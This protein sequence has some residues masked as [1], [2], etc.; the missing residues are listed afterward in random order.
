[1]KD[2]ERAKLFDKALSK[3]KLKKKTLFKI[4]L[5]IFIILPIIFLLLRLFKTIIYNKNNKNEKIFE[6]KFLANNTI[7]IFNIS[8]I[9][10]NS[11]I[12]NIT[13]IGNNSNIANIS[14]IGNKELENDYFKKYH[15]FNYLCNSHHL[16]SFLIYN[17]FCYFI[18]YIFLFFYLLKLI[19]K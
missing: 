19:N 18:K 12:T 5:I 17:I 9:G 14:N 16:P 8:D 2:L 1:M 15:I 11:N 3:Q 6:K 7:E 10:N 13:E 4:L